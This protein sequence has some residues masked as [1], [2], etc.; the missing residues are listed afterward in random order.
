MHKKCYIGISYFYIRT[1]NSTSFIPFSFCL[2]R[3]RAKIYTYSI[4]DCRCRY[5]YKFILYFFEF[6]EKPSLSVM[7]FAF[8]TVFSNRYQSRL[9]WLLIYLMRCE[10]IFMTSD[11]RT[12]FFPNKVV[13]DILFP[14]YNQVDHYHD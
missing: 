8:L 1:Q 11:K 7:K 4:V 5:Y 10:I 3:S 14:D 6:D 13:L 12:E 9:C 2:F